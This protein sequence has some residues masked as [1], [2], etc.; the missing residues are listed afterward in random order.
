MVID[1]IWDE[2]KIKSNRDLN[3]YST[4][5]VNQNIYNQIKDEFKKL[6]KSR[7]CSKR[8]LEYYFG[9]LIIIDKDEERFKLY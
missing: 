5:K 9:L 1:E 4:L 7:Y 2:Q 3:L 8:Y 6:F